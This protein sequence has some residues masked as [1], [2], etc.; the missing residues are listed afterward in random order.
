MYAS[1]LF[2]ALIAAISSESVETRAATHGTEVVVPTGSE[3][4]EQFG[5]GY[6]F[7]KK[8]GYSFFPAR[9]D[10]FILDGVR[11]EKEESKRTMKPITYHG[12]PIMKGMVNQYVIWYGNWQ[13]TTKN[14]EFYSIITGFLSSVGN[15]SWYSMNTQYTDTWGQVSGLVRLISQMG[16]GSTSYKY[17]TVLSTRHIYNIVFDALSSGSLPIDESGVY[18]VLTSSDV[19]QFD[20]PNYGFCTSGSSS[21]YCGWH[22]YGSMLNT[23]LLETQRTVPRVTLKGLAPMATGQPMQW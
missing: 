12:G 10:N 2:I 11:E 5:D 18:Y 23:P 4:S 16:F 14:Q 7:K 1:L 22:T 21:G 9:P 8:Y 13:N 19:R 20:S 3:A 15:S 17:G 6:D